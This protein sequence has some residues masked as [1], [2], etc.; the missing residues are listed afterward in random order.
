MKKGQLLETENI[1]IKEN[2]KT[3]VLYMNP[4]HW[5]Q[6]NL[7]TEVT[8]P[9]EVCVLTLLYINMILKLIHKGY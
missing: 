3:Y 1:H 6:A 2:K 9:I 4:L 7:K 5:L 8:N